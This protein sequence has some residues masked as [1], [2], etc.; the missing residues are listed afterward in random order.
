MES[1]AKALSIFLVASYAFICLLWL[2]FHFRS[3]QF[4]SF[5]ITP[6]DPEDI[7]FGENKARQG[8]KYCV[9]LLVCEIW[10]AEP[11]KTE[12]KMMVTR[13]SEAGDSG[14]VDQNPQNLQAYL[15][16][17]EQILCSYHKKLHVKKYVKLFHLTNP[18]C[19]ATLC[20]HHVL[21]FLEN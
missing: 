9:I 15:K 19:I 21:T 8:H 7:E 10:K 18:Q 3:F 14:D 4:L 5:V 13:G 6:R 1:A 16:I 11:I 2:I 12:R 17:T 20:A